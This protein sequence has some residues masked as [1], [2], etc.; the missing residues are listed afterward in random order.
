MAFTLILLNT[1]S[2]LERLGKQLLQAHVA[3]YYELPAMTIR[4]KTT[5]ENFSPIKMLQ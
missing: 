1:F 4:E 5:E 3:I 2:V